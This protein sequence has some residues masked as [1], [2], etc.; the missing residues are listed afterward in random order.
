MK[1]GG[2]LCNFIV[3]YRSPRQSQDD[4]ET[5]IK[6]FELN[7]GTILVNNPFLNVVL[8]HFN[9]KSNLWCKSEETSQEG[10][11]LESI[12]SQFRL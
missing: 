11:K 4:F 2:K 3:L 1:I 10:S 12:T 9:I 8:G 6:N 5:F 7:L